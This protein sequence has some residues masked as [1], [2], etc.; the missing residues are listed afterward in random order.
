M[1]F[2]LKKELSIG[3]RYYIAIARLLFSETLN[4][5]G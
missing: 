5:K 1:F 2:F 4:I 3:N